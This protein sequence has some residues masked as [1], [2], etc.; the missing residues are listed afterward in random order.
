MIRAEVR[1]LLSG[2]TTLVLVGVA[3][4]LN[5]LAVVGTAQGLE[6]SG[7]SDAEARAAF[8]RLCGLGFGASLFSMVLGALVVT[9]DFANRTIWRSA[10]LARGPL[11]LLGMRAA[12]LVLPSLL[13]VIGGAG[14]AVAVAVVSC[15]RAGLSV[16]FDAHT[17]AVLVGISVAIVLSTYLG[18]L[19]GW[20]VRRPLPAVIGLVAWTLF[21]EVA[22]IQVAA[23]VGKFLPGG[24]IQ[25][26]MLDTSGMSSSLSQPV[27]Y[28]VYVGWLL[29]L[30][31]AAGLLLRRRDL[32]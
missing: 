5:V 30:V 22:V 25:S 31:V 15:S 19:V 18:Y 32:L 16:T 10:I 23:G 3:V 9:R 27:G 2:R 12:A 17:R 4:L 11:R 26:I 24:A 7:L 13:F 29:L 21:V 20:L 14:A 6:L 1:R 28:L 8:A